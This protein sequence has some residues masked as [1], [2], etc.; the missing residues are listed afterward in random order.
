[1]AFLFRASMVRLLA[2]LLALGCLVSL[3]SGAEAEMSGK[4]LRT[5]LQ[6]KMY[7][8]GVAAPV[9]KLT[10]SDALDIIQVCGGAI[11]RLT[12]CGWVWGKERETEIGGA[13]AF[14]AL[15]LLSMR[16]SVS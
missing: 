1:M 3:F 9:A 14:G 12:G 5:Y 4:K 16:A 10:A 6:K 7:K 15:K 8:D 11:A 13:G 2:L